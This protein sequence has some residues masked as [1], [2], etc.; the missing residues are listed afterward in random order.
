MARGGEQ[1]VMSKRGR[2]L[3]VMCGIALLGLATSPATLG[4]SFDGTYTGKGVLTKGDT[5]SCP[6]EDDVSVTISDGTVIFTGSALQ[7]FGMGFYP[8]PDG[9]FDMMHTD[10]G[11]LVTIRGRI[12]GNTLDADVNN[13]AC[14][15]HW[16]LQKR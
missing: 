12:V 4:G 6:A 15:Y 13:I 7:N 8:Q 11:A 1:K 14:Q 10:G 2:V 16:H 3:S 9:S 5:P